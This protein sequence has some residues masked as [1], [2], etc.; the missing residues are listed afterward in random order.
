MKFRTAVKLLLG[1]EGFVNIHRYNGSTVR[2]TGFWILCGRSRDRGWKG[3][4]IDFC[5][6]FSPI[7]CYAMLQE[8][9]QKCLSGVNISMS[10]L[11]I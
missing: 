9:G 6:T 8:F 1:K 2:Q 11:A 5:T 7:Y 4:H 3:Q 10:P